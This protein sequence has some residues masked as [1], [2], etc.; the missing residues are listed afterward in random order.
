MEWSRRL[1][2]DEEGWRVLNQGRQRG[3]GMI[4]LMV[5]VVIMAILMAAAA[6]SFSNWI[7]GTRIRST[8]ES[9]LAGLQAARSEATTRNAQVRFQL[10]TSLDASCALS[11]S[12]RHWVIDLVD[13]DVDKDTVAGQCNAAPSASEPGILL[14]HAASGTGDGTAVNASADSVVFNGLGRQAPPIAATPLTTITFNVTPTD[15]SLCGKVTCLRVLVSP[16]GQVRMCNS[17]IVTAGDPQA[18]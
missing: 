7:S 16:A 9:V 1:L 18:C 17:H 5:A 14:V 4:E 12:G 10:T 6:P 11:T 3:V 13:A 2:G 8:A 15:T